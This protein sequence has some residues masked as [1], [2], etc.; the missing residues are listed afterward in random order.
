MNP[1]RLINNRAMAKSF[2]MPRP[3]ERKLGDAFGYLP[4]DPDI[5]LL[6]YLKSAH[7]TGRNFV[8]LGVPED[9]G[10]RANCGR[11]GA[12]EAWQACLKKLVN[13][14]SNQHFSGHNVLVL[15]QIDVADLM[16]ESLKANTD[17]TDLRQL[18][19]LLDERVESVLAVAFSA[20]LIPIVIGGGHN[21][22][23]PILRALAKNTSRTVGVA[24]LDP[25]LDF[26]PVA[27]ARHSG[28]SFSYA[29]SE[30]ILEKYFV[31]GS[32]ELYNSES[33]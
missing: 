32:H 7:N 16:A 31:L 2:I 28:N 5:D 30:G 11:P 25:H 13:G 19:A 20:N 8:I 23:L 1:L 3:F 14:Q 17:L 27:D 15:G 29:F 18:V 4:D 21:N 10:P 22:A 12:H 33:M 6:T 24:N 9:I 26:R